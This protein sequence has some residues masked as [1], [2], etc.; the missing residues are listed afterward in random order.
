MHGFTLGDFV[1]RYFVAC[2]DGLAGGDLG[3]GVWGCGKGQDDA[4][5]QVGFGDGHVILGMEVD[6]HV[7]ERYNVRGGCKVCVFG[8]HL[9]S[10][11]GLVQMMLDGVGWLS[12]PASRRA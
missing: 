1:Q 6:G 8:I 10:S 5:L 3:V 2:G 11:V 9:F 4:C 12:R 7:L